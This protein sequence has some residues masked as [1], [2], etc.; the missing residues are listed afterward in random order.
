MP[1]TGR[2]IYKRKDGR[3]EG[4]Y[5]KERDAGGKIIYGSVYGKSCTEVKQRLSVSSV[6]PVV[7]ELSDASVPSGRSSVPDLAMAFEWRDKDGKTVLTDVFS[8][9]RWGPEAKTAPLFMYGFLWRMTDVSV[10]GTLSGAGR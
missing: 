4:R 7:A 10:A 5:I 6:E 1:K 8:V 2:N 9:G 3:W